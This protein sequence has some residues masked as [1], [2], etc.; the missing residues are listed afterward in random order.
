MTHKSY[1]DII[2]FHLPC[3]CFSI[4]HP[5]VPS[6]RLYVKYQDVDA[7]EGTS[8]GNAEFILCRVTDM[9][10]IGDGCSRGGSKVLGMIISPITQAHIVCV[11]VCV[12][13]HVTYVLNSDFCQLS[14][15]A[16]LTF[17]EL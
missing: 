6:S 9:I 16:S 3:S 17:Q 1:P 13:Y 15:A 4:A 12:W 7:L 11:R 8:Y 5:K 14:E 2:L 10:H